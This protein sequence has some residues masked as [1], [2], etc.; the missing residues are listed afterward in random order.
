MTKLEP[1]TSAKDVNNDTKQSTSVKKEHK[2]R[3]VVELTTK[4]FMIL[5]D[6]YGNG[7]KK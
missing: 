7:N 3:A 6:L 1:I 5:K 4:P 2:K